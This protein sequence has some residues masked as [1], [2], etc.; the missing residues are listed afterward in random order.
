MKPADDPR[1]QSKYRDLT[2]LLGDPRIAELLR[3]AV[4]NPT[5]EKIASIV[6][7]YSSPWKLRGFERDGRVDACI[8]VEIIALGEAVIHH[9]AV[10]PTWRR[11]GLGRALI[12]AARQEFDL[13]RMSAETNS[14]SLGFYQRCGFQVESLGELFPGVERFLVI[15]TSRI[16]RLP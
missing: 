3:P 11:K 16:G 12:A 7:Q 4:G 5:P 2:R 10:A 13:Y 9:I 14:E 6:Q 1:G 8:G 15:W